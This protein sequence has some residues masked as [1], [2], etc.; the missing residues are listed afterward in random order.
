MVL[1]KPLMSLGI[2]IVMKVISIFALLERD[3]KAVATAQRD[4]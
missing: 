4:T 2:N 3:F 1:R